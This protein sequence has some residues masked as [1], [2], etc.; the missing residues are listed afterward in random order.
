MRDEWQDV[1][2]GETIDKHMVAS[3]VNSVERTDVSADMPPQVAFE[4][5]LAALNNMRLTK[6]V[7]KQDATSPGTLIPFQ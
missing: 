4:D 5:V 7:G 1:A 3:V 2:S 6:R